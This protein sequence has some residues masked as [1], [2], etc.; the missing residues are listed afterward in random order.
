MFGIGYFLHGP[1]VPSV[2]QAS[3][4]RCML[5]AKRERAS[6]DDCTWPIDAGILPLSGYLEPWQPAHQKSWSSG[7]LA[8]AATQSPAQAALAL[9]FAKTAASGLMRAAS[10]SSCQRGDG[11]SVVPGKSGSVRMDLGGRRLP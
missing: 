1:L 5:Y 3:A 10:A 9:G 8:V 6:R 11:K 7:R 4:W 2:P